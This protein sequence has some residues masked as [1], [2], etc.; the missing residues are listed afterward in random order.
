MNDQL[1]WKSM[2]QQVLNLMCSP[3]SKPPPQALNKEA[4]DLISLFHL[5]DPKILSADGGAADPLGLQATNATSPAAGIIVGAPTNP[6]ATAALP[7]P[8]STPP[9][10]PPNMLPEPTVGNVAPSYTFAVP[11][12]VGTSGLD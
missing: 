8:A 3:P 10:A 4:M 9:A 11:P 6:A 7:L 2:N 1:G 12:S 5:N